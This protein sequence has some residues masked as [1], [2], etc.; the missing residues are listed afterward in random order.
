MTNLDTRIYEKIG[1]HLHNLFE[2]GLV[3]HPPNFFGSQYF[4]LEVH[5]FELKDYILLVTCGMSSLPM[6]TPPQFNGPKYIELALKISNK[7]F[8]LENP[9]SASYPAWLLDELQV[10]A[11]TPESD[12]TF[13]ADGHS[14]ESGGFTLSGAAFI[15]VNPSRMNW[16]LPPCKIDSKKEVHFLQLIPVNREEMYA[17]L[18]FGR[19]ET[20]KR[21]FV[22]K[23]SDILTV[24]FLDKNKG[25]R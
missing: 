23:K 17:Y 4:H 11:R 22:D 6:H 3:A 24:A 1:D 8:S 16:N 9:V 2:S 18:R 5:I 15:M 19:D 25:R 7:Q 13:F 14:V 10:I 20:S 21:K 12:S